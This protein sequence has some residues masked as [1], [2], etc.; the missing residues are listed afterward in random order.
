MQGGGCATPGAQQSTRQQACRETTHHVLWRGALCCRLL[1]L[2]VCTRRDAA[3]SRLRHVVRSP[4]AHASLRKRRRITLMH[5][6]PTRTRLDPHVLFGGERRHLHRRCTLHHLLRVHRPRRHL[7]AVHLHQPRVMVGNRAAGASVAGARQT[8]GQGL[9]HL[10]LEDGRCLHKCGVRR[11]CSIK[12][13]RLGEAA[14][15]ARVC[16]WIE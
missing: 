7:H 1:R 16:V 13:E 2:G 11:V 8:C 3:G 5:S 9:A 12:D 6:P 4:R 14:G 15:V 10:S